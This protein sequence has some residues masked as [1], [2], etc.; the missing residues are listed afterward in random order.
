MRFVFFI[1][2]LIERFGGNV[3]SLLGNVLLSY[4]LS[5]DDFGMVTMLGVFS[6]LIFV[7]IDCGMSDGLLRMKE[8]S[9]K[10]FNTIF[11]FTLYCTIR[12]IY[13]GFFYSTNSSLIIHPIHSIIN[14]Y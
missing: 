6:S 3:V 11:Y 14:N 4:L 9:R 12:M 1:W 5:P 13:I 7:L 8:P 10:D 2:S